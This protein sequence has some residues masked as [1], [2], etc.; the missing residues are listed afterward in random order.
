M[1]PHVGGSSSAFRPRVER[2]IVDQIDRYVAGEPL[3]HVVRPAKI[4]ETGP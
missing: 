1:T 3:A 4:A 2:V